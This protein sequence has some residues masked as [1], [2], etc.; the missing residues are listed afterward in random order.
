MVMKADSGAVRYR[1]PG[2]TT[3]QPVDGAV[4]IPTGSV[5]DTTRGSI[6]LTSQIGTG[7][8]QGEFRGGE[9]R[10]RQH[11]KT[12]LTQV[13]LT[14]ALDCST[15]ATRSSAARK[16]SKRRHVWGKD[17]GGKFETHG[18][19][20]VAAVRGTKW[21]TTDTCAGTVIKVYEGAV[22]VKPKAKNGGKAKLL[23]AGGRSFTPY[24]P[25]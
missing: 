17:K 3:F 25:R 2:S 11:A 23:K 9:F 12:G 1:V 6:L 8:Q 19:A 15:K 20:S 4:S 14:G 7:S 22:L 16:K 18:R 5:V 10:V 24:K 21:L 13:V